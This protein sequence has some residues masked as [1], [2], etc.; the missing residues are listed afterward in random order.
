MPEFP[1]LPA[2]EMQLG[3]DPQLLWKEL[4]GVLKWAAAGAPR[5]QQ[6]VIGPSEI[7]APCLRRIGHKLAGTPPVNRGSAWRPVVGTATH[8]WLAS[9]LDMHGDDAQARDAL[10]VRRWMT[11]QRVMVGTIAGTEIWGTADAYDRI[12]GTVVDWKVVGPSTLRSVKIGGP[13]ETYQTQ[14]HLYGMGFFNGGYPVEHVAIAYMPSN[15]DWHDA[16][17]WNAE[18]D[19]EAA[20]KALARVEGIALALGAAGPAV[21]LPALPVADYYCQ[22]C[23][24]F[25]YRADDLTRACPGAMSG[26]S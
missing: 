6:S 22:G 13:S 24:F 21:V 15:G 8:A 9:A 19:P 12:T 7:G 17:Y 2:A 10:A 1:Q 18:W 14:L 23:P 11:E 16:V 3:S 26:N 4:L 5:S 20:I 25:A